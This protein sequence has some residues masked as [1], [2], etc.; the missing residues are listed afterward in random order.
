M[1][2]NIF[3]VRRL[4][5]VIIYVFFSYKEAQFEKLTRELEEEREKVAHR[6]QQV[7][8]CL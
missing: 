5:Y 1:K 6:V 7:N 8:P 2:F 4:I 3:K